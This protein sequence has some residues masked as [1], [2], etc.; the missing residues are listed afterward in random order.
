MN[1]KTKTQIRNRRHARIRA[2]VSGTASRPRLC[3]YKS[4][5]YLEAQLIDDAAG[6]TLAHGK[7]KDVAALAAHI[8]GEAKKKGIDKA[9]FD[10]GGFRYTGSVAAFAEAVRKSGLTF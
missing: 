5:R 7:M 6:K 3:V 9:V 2:T 8:A 10:R 4:N 1:A